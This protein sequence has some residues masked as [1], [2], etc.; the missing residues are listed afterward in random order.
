MVSTPK[1]KKSYVKATAIF[2]GHK[3]SPN[4]FEQ[5]IAALRSRLLPSFDT[6]KI[7]QFFELPK[8]FEIFLLRKIN[9]QN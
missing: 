4:V 2:Y 7:R 3:K 5:L 1:S 8:Y 9:L 6:E